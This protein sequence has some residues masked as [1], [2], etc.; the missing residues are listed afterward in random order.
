MSEEG[1]QCY[2]DGKFT[3]LESRLTLL[4][5]EVHQAHLHQMTA[6]QAKEVFRAT[7]LRTNNMTRIAVAVIAAIGM[8]STGVQTVVAA[9][10]SAA[11]ELRCEK[12]TS[13]ALILYDKRRELRDVE[14]A[15]KAVQLRDEEV[16]RIIGRSTR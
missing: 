16:D 2:L 7:A 10:D 4:E 13:D 1:L 6:E 14:I 15:R 5:R 3:N 12:G 11:L 9:H 8:T